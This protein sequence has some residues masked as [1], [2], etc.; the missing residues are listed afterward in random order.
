MKYLKKFCEKIEK[1]ILIF[2]EK[3]HAKRSGESKASYPS[4]GAPAG[5]WSCGQRHL[6]SVFAGEGPG[7]DAFFL[8]SPMVRK[9][10]RQR[11]N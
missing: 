4:C 6:Q 10:D 2:S 1:K 5:Q 9:N 7:I 3:K 8:F 11:K